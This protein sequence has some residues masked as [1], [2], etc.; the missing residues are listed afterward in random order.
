MSWSPLTRIRLPILLL[1]L[2]LPS[3]C[4]RPAEIERPTNVIL[5]SIDTLRADH[6]G[7]YGYPRP[8]SPT[9]DRLAAGGIVFEDVSSSAPWTLPAHASLLTGLYPN[10]NGMKS[11]DN[12]LPEQVS[13]LAELL[14][15][16]GFVTSAVVNSHNLSQRYGLD[17]GFASYTYIE[18]DVEQREHSAVEETAARWLTA[19]TGEPFSLFL[20]Y[21]D[22]HSDYRSLPAYEEQF[23]RPYHGEA[24][25]S[26]EQMLAFRRGKLTL[27]HEDTAH[28]VD[29]YD[30]GI[31]QMD[32]GIARLHALL[33]SLGY[34]DNTLLLITSDHG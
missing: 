6:L 19:H 32:D 1:I 14:Q 3:G 13:S 29:L 23:V 17:R 10:R 21:F 33:D 27:D 5:I 24:D 15:R 9:L 20:H 25:G 8:T 28:L 30:A 7:C 31:R 4:D 2:L 18:E 22:V 34:V 11:H 26:T 16:A 12:F